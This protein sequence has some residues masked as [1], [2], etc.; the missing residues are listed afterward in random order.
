MTGIMAIG[1]MANG[2]RADAILDGLI[3]KRPFEPM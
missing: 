1:H 3:G 2:I